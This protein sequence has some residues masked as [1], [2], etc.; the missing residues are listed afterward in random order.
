MTGSTSW[1]HEGRSRTRTIVRGFTLIELLVVMT[2][3]GLLLSLAVPRYYQSVARAK[4]TV[5]RENLSNVREAIDK[6][7]ADRGRYPD[8]LE[9]LVNRKYLRRLPFDPLTE[10]T[11]TWLLVPPADTTKGGLMDVHSGAPGKARDGTAYS[12]W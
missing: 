11:T 4:E 2:I 5:L 7:H 12:S 1:V 3:V 9:D 6:Y 8:D 10:S